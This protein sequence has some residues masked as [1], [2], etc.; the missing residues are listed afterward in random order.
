MPTF[1]A[2]I[3]FGRVAE[4]TL[5]ETSYPVR[6]RFVEEDGTREILTL[7]EV[8][9]RLRCSKAH[10]SKLLNGKVRG[11]P[12]LTHISMGRRKVVRRDWLDAWLN[13]CKQ[14]C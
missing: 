14:Q 8:A 11:V 1:F 3:F 4:L 9:Q 10:V 7:P 13:V 5:L 12:P 2:Q 6:G